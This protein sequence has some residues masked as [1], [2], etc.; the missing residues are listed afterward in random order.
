[1]SWLTALG[2]GIST[3]AAVVSV[4]AAIRTNDSERRLKESLESITSVA[5]WAKS[6]TE[7]GG[8]C[9]TMLSQYSA[10]EFTDF[11]NRAL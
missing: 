9:A 4:V 6:L 11:A 2:T 3:I 10:S 1:M 8:Q 5:E 7:S